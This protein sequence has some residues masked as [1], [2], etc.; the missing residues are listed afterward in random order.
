MLRG[1]AVGV[2]LSAS[3]CLAVNVGAGG[4][5]GAALADMRLQYR[6]TGRP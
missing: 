4:F 6:L 2:L 1:I 5:G 3:A